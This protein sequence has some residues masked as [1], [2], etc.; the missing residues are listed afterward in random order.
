MHNFVVGYCFFSIFFT[1]ISIG[2]I[3]SFSLITN[4]MV[5]FPSI[6]IGG[7]NCHRRLFTARTF[8]KPISDRFLRLHSTTGSDNDNVV[9][10]CTQ[11]IS[12]LLNP[13]KILVTSS[14]EDPNGSHVRVTLTAFYISKY[15]YSFSYHSF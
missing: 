5:S 2:G 10:R 12:A 14:N 6:L 11:K 1:I 3:N 7:L 15:S 4:K 9:T 8:A 13:L